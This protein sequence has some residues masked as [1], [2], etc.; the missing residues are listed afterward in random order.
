MTATIEA[1]K[2][3]LPA[4]EIV[5]RAK[6]GEG[7]LIVWSIDAAYPAER[8]DEEHPR[9]GRFNAMYTLEDGTWCSISHKNAK[10]KNLATLL[11]LEDPT[12][13]WATAYDGAPSDDDERPFGIG[14]EGKENLMAYRGR[15]WCFPSEGFN[16]PYQDGGVECE[17]CDFSTNDVGSVSYYEKKNGVYEMVIG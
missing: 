12:V 2:K 13:E 16:D 1:P 5:A 10:A 9:V 6:S 17:I 8:V 4:S 14:P 3:F 15:L 11:Q 7:G